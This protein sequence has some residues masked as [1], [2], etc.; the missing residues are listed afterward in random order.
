ML[1]SEISHGVDTRLEILPGIGK[2]QGIHFDLVG[3]EGIDSCLDIGFLAEDKRCFGFAYLI[4][5]GEYEAF[6]YERRRYF[7]VRT[8]IEILIII[9]R[10][11]L[12]FL[13]R[14]CWVRHV[15]LH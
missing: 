3:P 12:K 4:Y 9:G 11:I 7:N 6:G 2:L 10:N 5:G 1:S 14:L 13:R 15:D 8:V